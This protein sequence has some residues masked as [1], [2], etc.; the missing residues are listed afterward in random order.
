MF[1]F[2]LGVGARVGENS[3]IINLLTIIDGVFMVSVFFG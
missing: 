1:F 3:G 2:E